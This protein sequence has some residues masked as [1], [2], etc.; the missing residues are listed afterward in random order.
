VSSTA[1]YLND[2]VCPKCRSGLIETPDP[3]LLRCISERCKKRGL[4][5][6]RRPKPPESNEFERK[7]EE[8]LRTNEL[9]RKRKESLPKS[10][11]IVT[12]EELESCRTEKGGYR[13]TRA[14][15]TSWGVPWPPPKGWR[16]KLLERARHE[17]EVK[18]GESPGEPEG[19]TFL[20][21]SA[22]LVL[23]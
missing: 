12:L 9:E 23:E 14:R 21:R 7:R 3:R 15:L 8:S 5:Q 18:R 20:P 16:A 17:S 19:L 22:T 11:R 6:I 2:R 1:R 10:E 13:H 4:W